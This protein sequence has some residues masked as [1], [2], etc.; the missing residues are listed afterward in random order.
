M[1]QH[2]KDKLKPAVAR[3]LENMPIKDDQAIAV[4]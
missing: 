4:A 3:L 2:E 1:E